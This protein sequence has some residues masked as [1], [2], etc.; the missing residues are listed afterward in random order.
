IGATTFNPFFA[1]VSALLSRSLV[2][3]LK[4]LAPED[5]RAIMERALADRE[6]G[7]GGMTIRAEEEALA[8]LAK[9]CDGDARRALNALE[10]AALKIG[11]AS[12]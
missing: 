8:H 7:L 11:R 12:A 3:E 2:C 4:P 6:R 9:V 1:I 5:I 10:V